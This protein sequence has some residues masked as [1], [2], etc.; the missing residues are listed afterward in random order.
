MNA[1]Y[2]CK[3][4]GYV[5]YPNLGDKTSNIQPGTPFEELPDDWICPIC[6]AEKNFF[7]KG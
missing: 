4:C 7:I 2:K 5:Y 3:K 6:S 1:R